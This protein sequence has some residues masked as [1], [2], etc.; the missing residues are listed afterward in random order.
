MVFGGVYDIINYN[1]FTPH[2]RR[3]SRHVEGCQYLSDGYRHY[4]VTALIL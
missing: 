4:M 3:L 1:Y 2:T